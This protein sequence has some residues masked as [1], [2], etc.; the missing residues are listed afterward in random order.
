M[1]KAREDGSSMKVRYGKAILVGSSAAGKS[2]FFRLLMKRDHQTEHISTGLA[3]SHQLT[4]VMKVGISSTLE[5]VELDLEKEINELRQRLPKIMSSKQNVHLHKPNPTPD[6]DVKGPVKDAHSV[7]TGVEKSSLAIKKQLPKKE[8]DLQDVWNVLTFIDSG[9]QP[10][11]ISML[12]AV[13]SSAM[14]TFVVYNMKGGVEGIYSKVVVTHGEKDGIHTFEPHPID[15]TNY[16]LIK[17]LMANSND[18]FVQRNLPFLDAV[19][20]KNQS[21]CNAKSSYLSFI[22]THRDDV[23]EE[24]ISKLDKILCSAVSD[25]GM[26]DVWIH[27]NKYL[28][29]VDNTSAGKANEDENATV[30]RKRLHDV[31]QKQDIYEV[32]IAWII[33]ELEIRRL[34]KEKK[35]TFIAFSEVKKLCKESNLSSDEDFIKNGLKFHHLFGVLLYYEE[36]DGMRDIVITDH[37]WLLDKLTD[38]V[39]HSYSDFDNTKVYNDFEHK[40]IFNEKLLEKVDFGREYLE[41][42]IDLNVFDIKNSFLNLLQHL[43]IIAPVKDNDNHKRYF[44][45]SL[46]ET[47]NPAAK[48]DFCDEEY[49]KCI[50]EPLLIQFMLSSSGTQLSNQTG[51]FPRGV[52]CCL[53]VELMQK[54][55]GWRLQW[56]RGKKELF[57]NLV[58]FYLGQGCYI[59]LID[60]TFYLEIQIRRAYSSTCFQIRSVIDEALCNIGRR[61]HFCSFVL[62]YGFLCKECSSTDD[63]IARFSSKNVEAFCQYNKPTQLKPSHVVWF[64]SQSEQKGIVAIMYYFV[65]ACA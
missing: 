58:T 2:S 31:L 52:F 55:E 28:I 41:S 61:L 44:M 38:I 11:Y 23:S 13:N 4:S 22:G 64:E 35:C 48:Q 60:K 3:D 54:K 34:C 19:R 8:K 53:V 15:C 6:A 20:V 40:G 50:N 45:P 27:K 65:D 14:I 29:P 30:I 26:E 7:L 10:Q 43:R 56:S 42:G 46:L 37:Q 25:S 39:Y 63:H 17:T 47:C 62:S 49:G 57:I 18:N 1:L 5:F 59:T 12:P 9:G 32:P 21:E 16:Q 51:A 36:V 24:V 33:L